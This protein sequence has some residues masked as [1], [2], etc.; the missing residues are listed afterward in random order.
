MSF[1]LYGPAQIGEG[2]EIADSVVII[3]PVIIGDRVKISHGAVIGE[4]GEH[5]SLS[6]Q[7]QEVVEIGDDTVIREH[8]VVQRGLTA[9]PAEALQRRFWGT[10]IGK[11]CL[12]MHGCHIAHDCLVGDHVTM[13]PFVVLGGH[14]VVLDYATMGIHSATHQKVT[15]GGVAMVGMGSIVLHDVPTAAKVVGVPAR[16]IGINTVGVQRARITEQQMVELAAKWERYRGD[17]PGIKEA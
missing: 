12:I 5:R 15:V 7:R 17:R 3:G 11:N 10:R 16:V 14:T 2:C 1:K 13:S 4:D 9:P 8:V 6:S